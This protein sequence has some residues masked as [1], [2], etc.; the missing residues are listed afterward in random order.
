MFLG[1]RDGGGR[2]ADG[3][4]RSRGCCPVGPSGNIHWRFGSGWILKQISCEMQSLQVVV[5][6]DLKKRYTDDRL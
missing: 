4:D 3:V 6:S 2:G 1:V 5:P